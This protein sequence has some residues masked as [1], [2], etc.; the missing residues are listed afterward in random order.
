MIYDSTA[1]LTLDS[2]G[3]SPPFLCGG[4]L[5]TLLLRFRRDRR[6]S[7]A[8][9][10]PITDA[11]FFRALNETVTGLPW[12]I[13]DATL[14][15]VTSHYKNCKKSRYNIPLEDGI[16]SNAFIQEI[17]HQYS[18]VE[19]RMDQFALGYV[20]L[21]CDEL[22]I[23]SLIELIL[24]D[25]TILP[26]AHFFIDN[27]DLPV[28]KAQ[29][30]GRN[31]FTLS[32]FLIGIIQYVCKNRIGKN[33]FGAS[34][35]E[36]WGSQ[37]RS[38]ERDL[39][40]F[41]FGSS[42]THELYVYSPT[43][44]SEPPPEAV[45][46]TEPLDFD[47]GD[48]REKYLFGVWSY[49]RNVT[50]ATQ[51]GTKAR[52]EDIYTCSDLAYKQPRKALKGQRLSN[53]T[54]PDLEKHNRL[55]QVVGTGGIGKSMM[56]RGFFLERYRAY[57]ESGILPVL[58]PAK[59]YKRTMATLQDFILSSMKCFAKEINEK[60]LA[61]L[62]NTGKIILFMDGIDEI[63]YSCLDDFQEKLDNFI[64]LY[65]RIT[66]VCSSRDVDEKLT[67]NGFSIF[68]VQK[69][70][71]SQA[72]ELIRKVTY[73]DTAAKNDLIRILQETDLYEQHKE[74]C[75]IPLLLIILL[76]TYKHTGNIPTDLFEFYKV[77]FETMLFL[78][79]GTKTNFKRIFFTSLSPNTFAQYFAA[80]CFNAHRNHIQDF[81]KESFARL[82]NEVLDEEPVSTGATAEDFLFDALHNVCILYQG[83]DDSY[84]FLHRGFLEYLTAFHIC[85]TL[86]DNYEM[87]TDYFDYREHAWTDDGTFPMVYS[88]RGKD[89]D[90]NMFLPYLEKLL[91]FSGDVDADYWQFLLKIY[92][93]INILAVPTPS[94]V[95]DELTGDELSEY[96]AFFSRSET[97]KE[98][99][100]YLYNFF[101]QEKGFSH[102][103]E[104]DS[105]SWYRK[106]VTQFYGD[107][108][109]HNDGYEP[110]GYFSILDA[111]DF[112]ISI[113]DDDSFYGLRF[114]LSCD[115]VLKRAE[116]DMDYL[117]D[118]MTSHSFPL[119]REFDD[120]R[121]WVRRAHEWQHRFDNVK[122]KK[123]ASQKLL[124]F[125]KPKGL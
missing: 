41:C 48:P 34:T 92:P 8:T 10:E 65:P 62:L 75:G 112:T 74:Y 87:Y 91:G 2:A 29:L 38:K 47:S 54:V 73:W 16:M 24:N 39:S 90:L 25:S 23:K 120:L 118:Q 45:E 42:I 53:L 115:E 56:M 94:E 76:I 55:L 18:V 35:L 100:F 3:V 97:S 21:D 11:S 81:T 125:S 6:L 119:R 1:V 70:T 20:S 57:K 28:T 9:I 85:S 80:F 59:D 67:L 13:S 51:L 95:E 79:D 4:T 102:T 49:H 58:I 52:F 72:I 93:S 116:S 31:S 84:H 86:D 111:T 83:A 109:V 103:N 26:S 30:V 7:H 107:Y 50:I 27:S 99:N 69:L 44:I 104:L 82:M 98:S 33:I 43:V 113:P 5:L 60:I 71:L 124:H 14:K 105:F 15:T 89:L 114:T 63:P 32:S 46:I 108:I 122:S 40:N 88:M 121:D 66:I 77:A 22:L 106:T 123:A 36:Y 78:H 117:Y 12:S 17:N 96:S 64:K 110:D 61:S 19:S 101:I 37:T 68:E